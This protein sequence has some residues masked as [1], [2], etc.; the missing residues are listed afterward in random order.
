MVVPVPFPPPAI[1]VS[2]LARWVRVSIE[3]EIESVWTPSIMERLTSNG[4]RP[5]KAKGTDTGDNPGH[6][7]V[8]VW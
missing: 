8:E 1:T 6:S 4:E 7:V 2:G 3:H 5:Q